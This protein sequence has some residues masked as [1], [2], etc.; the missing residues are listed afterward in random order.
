MCASASARARDD[1]E[2]NKRL[3][4]WNKNQLNMFY[5][6]LK[7]KCAN[8]FTNLKAQWKK[9]HC[10]LNFHFCKLVEEEKISTGTPSMEFSSK[11][12]KLEKQTPLFI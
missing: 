2:R 8:I 5:G 3:N 11:F 4:W 6:Y 7:E 10:Q 12:R 9:S 1:V